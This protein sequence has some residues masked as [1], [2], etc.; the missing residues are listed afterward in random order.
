MVSSTCTGHCDVSEFTAVRAE[1]AHLSPEGHLGI[2]SV[3][4]IK[5]GENQRDAQGEGSYCM[6]IICNKDIPK[7][8]GYFRAMNMHNCLFRLAALVHLYS[9]KPCSFGCPYV[10]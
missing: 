6:C 8:E 2:F 1:Y 5:R 10:R 9:V 7:Y 3:Y 4:D